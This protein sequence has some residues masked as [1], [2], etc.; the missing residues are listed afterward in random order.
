LPHLRAIELIFVIVILGILAAV[1][2]P[3]F[4]SV[5]EDALIASEKAG[6][7][8]VRSGIQAINGKFTANNNKDS[9]FVTTTK[10][11]GTDKGQL[12]DVNVT[13][14]SNNN[15]T[16]RNSTFPYALSFGAA[17]S[18]GTSAN[19]RNIYPL[20]TA[21]TVGSAIAEPLGIVIE[22]GRTQYKTSALANH[23]VSSKGQFYHIAGPATTG[24]ADLEAEINKGG[25]WEY[26]NYTG[27]VSW[28]PN[29]AYADIPTSD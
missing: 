14:G 21:T 28:I 18:A 2:M 1:A 20:I 3:R 16:A 26:D 11:V 10:G 12:V 24:V 13:R 23:S 8:N 9:V 6:I 15:G 29:V 19:G 5:Q 25:H 17:A 7:A 27:L 22:E 4:A